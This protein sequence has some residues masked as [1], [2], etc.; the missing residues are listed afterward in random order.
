MCSRELQFFN[1]LQ[2]GGDKPVTADELD[3]LLKGLTAFDDLDYE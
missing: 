3:E 1:L 2:Y